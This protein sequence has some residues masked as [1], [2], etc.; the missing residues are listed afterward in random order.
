MLGSC[1]HWVKANFRFF[2]FFFL[3]ESRVQQTR[4]HRTHTS[5]THI[6]HT[7]HTHTHTHTHTQHADWWGHNMADDATSTEE[8]F[9]MFEALPREIVY[10]IAL[11]DPKVVRCICWGW[12]GNV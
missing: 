11:S 10:Q 3:C 4:T 2:F 9:A 12:W 8:S 6:A 1:M 7:P 5:H